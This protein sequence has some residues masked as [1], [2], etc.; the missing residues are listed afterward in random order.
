MEDFPLM[1]ISASEQIKDAVSYCQPL[2]F[3]S[4]VNLV[5]DLRMNQNPIVRSNSL[6]LQ[7]VLINLVSNAIKY[8]KRGSDIR[9]HTQATS[10][11]NVRR[12]IKRAMASSHN[13]NNTEED[14]DMGVLV[15]SVVDCGPGIA[16]DQASRLFQQFAQ[17]ESRPRRSIGGSDVGQPPGT[18]VGL[19][20]CKLFVNRM[21]GQIW[22]TN[23][24]KGVDGTTFSFY[25]PL[26]SCATYD[27]VPSAPILNRVSDFRSNS[28][29]SAGGS[30]A[31]KDKGSVFDY[32]VLVVDDIL[33]NRKVFD[34]MVKKVGVSY[35]VT[36]DSGKKALEELSRNHFDLVITDLQMPGMSGTE[37]SAA[38]RDSNNL[39]IVPIVVGL[40][41]DTSDDAVTR[42]IESG[43]ADMMYKPITVSEMKDYFETTVPN[44]KR[45]IWYKAT[46]TGTSNNTNGGDSRAQ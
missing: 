1:S 6:R 18:G 46:T 43:M 5:T 26:V 12:M 19:H 33:I 9:I 30:C 16:R 29:E 17:L 2:A 39:S 34:R 21:N 45:G 15:F 25:L 44:L 31:K 10:L 32:R 14:D 20:L 22:A 4:N 24:R 35:S 36:V 23:N 11:G 7:Q 40:T 27:S 37:L 41:A 8:S 42:C 28:N 3:T 38:I 13:D